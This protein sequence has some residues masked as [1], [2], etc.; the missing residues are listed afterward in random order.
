MSSKLSMFG[1]MVMG[2]WLPFTLALFLILPARRA[3]IAASILGM[4]FLPNHVFHFAGLPDY[5]KLGAISYCLLAGVILFDWKRLVNFRFLPYDIPALI[6][7][8]CPFFTSLSNDLGAYDGISAILEN[9]VIWGIPYFLGRLYLTDLEAM[10]DLA[11]GVI[12]GALIYMPFCWYE[13]KMSPQ[14]HRMFYGFSQANIFQAKRYGGWRPVVFMNHGLMV[15]LWMTCGTIAAVWMWYA[16]GLRRLWI[17]PMWMIVGICLATTILVKSTFALTLLLLGLGVLWLMR[18]LRKPWPIFL[19][20]LLPPLY[21]FFRGGGY[22]DGMILYDWS[23]AIFGEKRSFSL[24]TRLFNETQIAEKAMLR[25][26]LGWG[27]WGRYFVNEGT[28]PDGLWI[29]ALGKFGIVGLA[30]WTSMFLLPV[31]L[32]LKAYPVRY[33]KRAEIAPVAIVA[34]T[35]CVFVVDSL[36]NAMHTTAYLVAAGGLTT[37]ASQV[38][39]ARGDGYGWFQRLAWLVGGRVMKRPGA[40]GRGGSPRRPTVAPTAKVR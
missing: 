28:I 25:P 36:F 19:L 35:C 29:T 22:W 9:A 7:C 20:A 18:H 2:G 37:T 33:W 4:L 12:L 6:W 24:L 26:W 31:L 30:A 5:D 16:R 15:G 17:V 8:I 27:R 1:V 3:V 23:V 34:V 10:R 38:L 11:V 21:M 13:M 40:G 32:A 14:L 39:M